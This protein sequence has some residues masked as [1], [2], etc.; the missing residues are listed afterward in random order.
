MADVSLITEQTEKLEMQAKCC[1]VRK[2]N[3]EMPLGRGSM[4]TWHS[5]IHFLTDS[6][7]MPMGF[8][9]YSMNTLRGPILVV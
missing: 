8:M 6:Y 3:L 1:R 2:E 5:C 4:K 9:P 7:G